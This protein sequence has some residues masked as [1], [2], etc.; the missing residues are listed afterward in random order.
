MNSDIKERIQ[1]IITNEQADEKELILQLKQAIYENEVQTNSEKKSRSL[2]E[3]VSENLKYL[4]DKSNQVNIVKSGFTDF[5][6]AFGGFLLGE[7]V[8]IGARPGMGKTLLLINLAL[9]ISLTKPVLY[10]TFD[11]S[12]F[13]LTNRFISTL[14]GI[15]LNNIL[16]HDFS[17]EQGDIIASIEPELSNRKIFISESISNYFF[18]FK[19]H[20][21]KQIQENGIQVIFVDY[22]QLLTASKNRNNRELEISFICRELKKLAK[23]HNVCIICSSQLSRAVES[24]GGARIPQLADL[25]ESGA[26][27]QDADK[28]MFIYRPAY[29]NIDI[30]EAGNNTEGVAEIYISKNSSGKNGMVRLKVDEAFTSFRDF[31]FYRNEFSF[32]QDRLYEMDSPF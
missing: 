2:T 9:N 30:D 15:P 1:R 29:Y 13:L 16:Q 10:F 18:P 8:V 22:L 12:E 17:N 11:L 3:L 20:C 19:E 24:R 26:I 28:V 4:Q 27:E 14:S 5:D 23:E 25:R 32:R 6:E 31:D 7:L 21:I